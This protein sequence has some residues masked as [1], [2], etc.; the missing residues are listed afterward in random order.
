VL[1]VSQ[2]GVTFQATPQLTKI[3]PG[4]SKQKIVDATDLGAAQLGF[5]IPLAVQVE[6]G[7]LSCEGVLNPQDAVTGLLGQLHASLA[8]ATFIVT[9]SDDVTSYLFQAYVSD[10]KPFSVALGKM[11]RVSWKL[12]IVGAFYATVD[13]GFQPNAFQPDAFQIVQL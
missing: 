4:G 13:S 6:S 2:D 1:Q 9:L 3:E 7:D 5:T 10:W 12:R 8:L 11:L